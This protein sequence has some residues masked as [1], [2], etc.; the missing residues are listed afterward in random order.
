MAAPTTPDALYELI[1][2]SGI[3][4]SSVLQSYR[5][6]VEAKGNAPTKV[7]HLAR[8]L[9]EAGILTY[10]QAEQFLRGKWR[11]FTIGKYRILERLGQGGMGMV[12]LAEHQKMKHRV[13][14]KVLPP[15]QAERPAVVERFHREGR[16]A[17]ALQHPNLVRGFDIDQDGPLH[18]LVMEYVNGVNLQTLVSKQGP[19]ALERAVHYVGQ[20]AIGLQYAH[21]VAGLV[22]RDI[23]PGNLLL[24]RS[25][26]VKILD[27]GLARFFRDK[28]D[29]L[30]RNYN[31]KSI[32]GTADYLA[33]EQ[34]LDSSAA[35]IRSDL[36][37][38]GGTFFFFLTGKP[39]F[40]SNSVTQKLVW[41]QT[42]EP[43]SVQSLRPD[44]PDSIAA[45]I[46]RLMAKDPAKRF[47]QPVE[48]VEA[49]RPW[50]AIPLPP[51]SPEE[52]PSLCRAAQGP[53]SNASSLSSLSGLSFPG[54]PLSSTDAS[55]YAGP[56]STM[57]A[58]DTAPPLLEVPPVSP[59]AELTPTAPLPDRGTVHRWKTAL[60]ISIVAVLVTLSG[61]GLAL[62][63]RSSAAQPAGEKAASSAR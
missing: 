61:L 35:D 44:V 46:R 34:A 45:I 41:H 48:L 9:V 6:E 20:V 60:V 22:H 29:N 21:E 12:Y 56:G 31:D 15:D 13:A 19:L 49:L 27:M 16:A 8:G 62:W 10:F 1:L 50:L 28:T 17:A 58:A 26:T 18:Y 40:E 25:G 30:T 2:R 5:D 36:Y 38:L 55:R 51:P 3:I 43:R 4:E 54:V 53:I 52:I 59:F 23:K 14:I 37:S 7:K 11:G 57:R 42:R 33:P 32:L 47:Q 39:P 24:D 63:P